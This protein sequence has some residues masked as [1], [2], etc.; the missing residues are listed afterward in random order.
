MNL[1]HT[2]IHK[3]HHSPYFEEAITF[4]LI[5]FSMISHG[6]CIQMSFCPKI[7]EIGTFVTLEAHNFLFK[8]L[9]KVRFKAKL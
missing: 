5:V 6:G 2:R 4:S 7:L 3:T 8:P 9:I 1:E